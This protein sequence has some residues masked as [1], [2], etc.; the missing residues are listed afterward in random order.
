MKQNNRQRI[1]KRRRAYFFFNDKGNK[2]VVPEHKQTYWKATRGSFISPAKRSVLK[3]LDEQPYEVGGN[4]DFHPKKGLEQMTMNFGDSYM[5]EWEVDPDFEATYHTH[6]WTKNKFENYINHL[7][8]EEDTTNFVE[9]DNEKMTLL[10]HGGGN[11]TMMVK[12]KRFDQ[13]KNKLTDG[14]MSKQIKDLHVKLEEEVQDGLTKKHP[15]D[16]TVKDVSKLFDKLGI[17]L[18]FVPKTKKGSIKV[19]IEVMEKTKPRKSKMYD[20]NVGKQGR[21]LFDYNMDAL[22]NVF[23]KFEYTHTPKSSLPLNLNLPYIDE[24]SSH[25]RMPKIDEVRERS[26]HPNAIM[27]AFNI[28]SPY[29]EIKAIYNTAV[30]NNTKPFEELT[31]REL[32]ELNLIRGGIVGKPNGLANEGIKIKKSTK[33]ESSDVLKDMF[34]LAKKAEPNLTPK[35]YLDRPI[36]SPKEKKV[37]INKIVPILEV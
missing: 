10:S 26:R 7:P 12:T 11:L 28:S 16:E 15:I 13:L 31:R 29:Q 5:A 1:N 21:Y 20:Y 36:F 22:E 8:S 23:A 30:K 34:M 9:F 19:P 4:M 32:M 3:F 24:E 14:Q 33:Q 2:V 35:Q 17:K 25:Y 6:P 27:T 37:F 18:V